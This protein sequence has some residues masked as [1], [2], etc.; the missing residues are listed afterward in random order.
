[1]TV[2]NVEKDLESL[3]M[4][5]TCEYEATAEE[6]WQLWADPRKLERWWGPPTYPATVVD[7]DLVE[8]GR[9]SYYMTGPDGHQP[10]GWWLVTAVEPPRRLE[11]TDGFADAEG[12]HLDTMPSN[13]T[14]VTLADRPSGGTVMTI[15]AEFPSTE[16]ME[17]LLA[18]GMQ[19]GFTQALGQ[20]DA[21]LA[22]ISAT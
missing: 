21:A 3:T 11:F 4:T 20:T 10:H 14:M 18:M 16:D 12:N 13:R 8:G 5:L 17:K 9:V 19:E 1:M 6:V 2:T 15:V 22:S 7:H